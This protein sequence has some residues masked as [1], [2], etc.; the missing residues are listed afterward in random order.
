MGVCAEQVSCFTLL[1]VVPDKKKKRKKRKDLKVHRVVQECQIKI[2][3]GAK[4]ETRTESRASVDIF[5][6]K[7]PRLDAT[8]K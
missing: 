3:S 8:V 1:A 6:E 7:S 5:I 4:S 2:C